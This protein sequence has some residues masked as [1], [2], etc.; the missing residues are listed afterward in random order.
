MGIITKGMGAIMKGA[1]KRKILTIST[2]S[3]PKLPPRKGEVIIKKKSKPST[4]KLSHTWQDRRIDA[5]NRKI[6]K[7]GRP[8]T[9]EHYIDEYSAVSESKAPSKKIYKSVQKKWRSLDPDQ[10]SKIW[11]KRAQRTPGN[12]NFKKKK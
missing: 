2:P 1:K 11:M 5:M 4:T 9:T 8:G 6:K 7:S 3:K 12:V 10:Q